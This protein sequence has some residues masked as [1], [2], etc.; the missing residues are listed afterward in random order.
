MMKT[1][2]DAA[3]AATLLLIFQFCCLFFLAAQPDVA[4]IDP[5]RSW[6][7]VIGVSGY[8]RAEPLAYAASDAQAFSDFLKSPRGGALP[9]DRVFTLLEERASRTGIEY[10][11]EQ[12]WDR[13]Q[14]GDRMIAYI[15][16]HGLINKRGIAYFLPVDGDVRTPNSTSINLLALQQQLTQGFMHAGQRILITDMCHA[17]TLGE[18]QNL[19]NDYVLKQFHSNGGGSFLNLLASGSDEPS[20]ESEE[21]GHGVFTYVLLEGL[22]GRGLDAAGHMVQA[23]QVVDFVKSEV[24]KWTGQQQN[25]VVNDSFEQTLHLSYLDR[26][27]PG[28]TLRVGDTTL[29][30]VN[31]GRSPFVRTK[32]ID[33]QDE[34]VIVQRIPPDQESFRISSLQPGPCEL[35]FFDTENNGKRIRVTLKEGENRLDVQGP[36]IGQSHFSD[37]RTRVAS[38]RP[39]TFLAPPQPGTPSG[40]ITAATC[41][42]LLQPG[43]AADIYL[44]G[45]FY[46]APED[47]E[48]LLQLQG[49]APGPR[50]L[51]LVYPERERRF[52]VKLLPGRQLL[53]IESGELLSLRSVDLPPRFRELPELIPDTAGPLY[54]RFLQAIWER[55]LVSPSGNC[56]WDFYQQLQQVLDGAAAELARRELIVAM[57]DQAHRVILR[58]LGG[59]DV[60]WESSTFREGESLIGRLQEVFKASDHYAAKQHF[61]RGRAVLEEGDYRSATQQLRRA[62]QLDPEASYA[63]NALGLA[64]WQQGR[65]SEALRALERSIE[66]TPRWNYPR[67]T[68]ALV[69]IEQR[70]YP[71]A[72]RALEEALQV[73]PEDSTALRALAQLLMLT[74]RIAQA[75]PRLEAAVEFHPGN[76][77]A[78]QSLG[79]L[80]RR[81]LRHGEAEE[82]Y[83][84]AILL[85]PSEPVFR[86][87]LADL[88]Y[89]VGR[90]TEAQAVHDQLQD[91]FA[92]SPRVLEARAAFLS[93]LG[94]FDAADSAYRKALE[95]APDDAT[96]R[97]NYAIFLA[98]QQRDQKAEKELQRVLRSNPKNPFALFQLAR[99][100]FGNHR[101]QEAE[102]FAMKA[103][104][105]DPYYASAQLLLGQIRF[106]RRKHD[107]A[108]QFFRQAGQHAVDGH[109]RQQAQEAIQRV[110]SIL[111]QE[112]LGAAATQAGRG[113][114]ADAWRTYR[115]ALRRAGGHPGIESS[116]IGF[117]NLSRWKI[118]SFLIC[119]P[120]IW[121]E[122]SKPGCGRPI[123]RR[124]V[125]GT[126]TGRRMR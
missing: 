93:A 9:P 82:S 25:P 58:Y 7:L 117:S 118:P 40:S 110:E 46:G 77:Y 32:W 22:N 1:P 103:L 106:A 124:L 50:N 14:D 47:P 21:L 18:T 17:G 35:E 94:Q 43:A 115:E 23:S 72:E 5:E 95:M 74:G 49:L 11:L 6:A 19:I 84:L 56:A 60:K 107:E 52:R 104:K 91:G 121:P 70:L 64:F 65:F 105:E 26:P 63:Y 38:L 66:L 8:S 51:R 28:Q 48:R 112:L 92:S 114:K 86:I 13:V 111:V 90:I 108:L 120:P 16:G 100:A 88:L 109:Q 126:R 97:I 3:P 116:A 68:R 99:M 2:S 39:Q 62:T 76:A 123:R 119:L 73:D 41:S 42:L 71:Q 20:W 30:L 37:G 34:T 15:A 69:L 102:R 54:R 33:N 81:Q 61:F 36:E 87:E 75:R 57:G 59:G 4:G 80:H 44:D 79:N 12:M 45:E 10:E 113:R 85:E 125:C 98:G 96:L 24:P 83:R 89:Q 31:S 122:L 29:L 53:K 55:R 78:Y 101:I 67:V 27:G